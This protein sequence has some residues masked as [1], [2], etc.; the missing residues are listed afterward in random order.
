MDF[1]RHSNL[2]HERRDNVAD[3]DLSIANPGEKSERYRWGGRKRDSGR[4]AAS[5][6]CEMTHSE[7]GWLNRIASHQKPAANQSSVFIINRLVWILDYSPIVRSCMP[8]LENTRFSL[9]TYKVNG[10]WNRIVCPV[11]VTE[12]KE[13]RRIYR[14][15]IEYGFELAAHCN[16]GGKRDKEINGK[17]IIIK[18]WWWCSRLIRWT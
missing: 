16:V 3:D 9:F 5:N 1:I 13:E 14:A 4:Q 17:V 2:M 10:R 15:F 18:M 11:I 6:W 8:C 12:R 7:R